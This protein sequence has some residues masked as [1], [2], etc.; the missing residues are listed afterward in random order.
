MKYKLV[1]T[2]LI[3]LSIVHPIFSQ[4]TPKCREIVKLTFQAMDEHSPEK[5]I[6]YLAEDFTIAGR[7]GET[8]KKVLHQ[9]ISQLTINSYEEQNTTDNEKTLKFIYSVDYKGLGVKQSI[10][11]FNK[12][13]KLEALE[14]FEMKIKVLEEGET[15]INKPSDDVIEIPFD[16]VRNLITVNVLLNG[17]ERSFLFDSGSP[18][19]VLNSRYISTEKAQKTFSSIKDVNNNNISGMDITTVQELSFGGIEIKEQKV[20]T[21]DLSHLEKGLEVEIY[22]LIGFEMIKDYDVLLDYENQK[23]ILISPDA[24]GNF[25]R[26]SLRNN[27]L[28]RIPVKMRGHLPVIEVQIDEHHLNFGIDTGAEANLIDKRLFADLLE[29]IDNVEQDN[30]VGGDANSS[31]VL[32]GLLETMTIKDKLYHSIY[33]VFTNIDHLNKDKT[34]EIDGLIGYPILSQQKVIMSFERKEIFF[35][36]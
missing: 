10:F 13:C 21:T 14:L 22:G 32:S 27:L 28:K 8:A 1:L 33:T 15:Q 36:E 17:Q 24:F 34:E 5:L 29:N 31:Q 25:R 20:V 11:T 3:L 26:K 35:I 6:P 12:N 19:V 7:Q 23:M 16:M 30:L 4:D 9:L 18:R 2:I